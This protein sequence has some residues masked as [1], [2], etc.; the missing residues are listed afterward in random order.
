MFSNIG[1][2]SNI[3]FT[4]ASTAPQWDISLKSSIDSI[5][6]LPEETT[7]DTIENGN[8]DV[9]LHNKEAFD[10]LLDQKYYSFQELKERK[11]WYSA[12]AEAYRD[13]RPKYPNSILDEALQTLAPE[14]RIL[15]IGSGPGTATIS[16]AQRG[17][18][19]TCLEPNPE[20]CAMAQER[21]D[22]DNCSQNVRIHNIA[23]EEAFL[24]DLD[25]DAVVAAT[26]IHW[27]PPEVAFLKAS[28][29]LKSGG[30]LILLWNMMVTPTS[31]DVYK[32]LQEAHGNDFVTLLE[33]GDEQTQKD[34]AHAAGDLMMASGY[35]QDLRTNEG[36]Q[37]VTYNAAQYLGLLS[38]Y[39]FYM[40][41]PRDA[42]HLLFERI[43]LVIDNDFGGSIELSH[44]S[45]Y[46]TATKKA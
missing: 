8:P 15:E 2:S 31:S 42:Q 46:H 30:A 29:A 41:L 39:S 19:I 38:T 27:I 28:Q 13:Y 3:D 44:I 17:F 7:C 4:P 35:F 32:R 45:L 9:I 36:Q 24:K 34:V 12:N 1:T 25:F 22:N 37:T 11:G 10:K 18:H 40:R 5:C 33:W 20:F 26:S 21:L 43:R 23:F 14:A 16:L 6:C